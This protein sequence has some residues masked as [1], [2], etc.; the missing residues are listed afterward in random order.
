[1]PRV[2]IIE[3]SKYI[4]KT[5][6][7]VRV[8][9]LNYGNHLANESVLAYAHQARIAFLSEHGKSELDF[10][11]TSLIQGDAA[12]T[13][14]SEGFLSNNISIE[15]GLDDVSNS[16]FDFVYKMVNETTGKGL[17]LVKTRMVCFN[18]DD[19]KVTPVPEGFKSLLD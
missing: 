17:A 19:R 1:M 12:I 9:D 10:W 7:K 4:H 2:K 13:Y 5:H 11:G 3:P 6:I 18:Y 15:L 16:S 8:T 14:Q